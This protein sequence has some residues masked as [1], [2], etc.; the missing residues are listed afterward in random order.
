MTSITI[1]QVYQVLEMADKCRGEIVPCF[2]GDPGI[3]KTESVYRF[4]EDHGRN[5]VEMILSQRQ[6]TEI[7]GLVMP[8]NDTKS[9]EVFDHSRLSELK[10]GD[11]LLFDELLEAPPMVLSACLT[12]IQERRMMS[13]KKLPDILICAATNPLSSPMMIKESVRQRFMWFTVQFSWKVFYNHI[14][15][16]FGIDLDDGITAWVLAER[17]GYNL[18]TPRSITKLIELG[19]TLDL[20]MSKD[21]EAFEFFGDQLFQ[22]HDLTLKILKSLHQ[23]TSQDLIAQALVDAYAVGDLASSISGETII[24]INSKLEGLASSEI[25]EV[26]KSS[27]SAGE[28]E[29]VAKVLAQVDSEVLDA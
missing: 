8:D 13:G 18:V 25:L 21:R 19:K 10:D 23:L 29:S 2:V 4:A 12:L 17:T 9:M 11:I 28:F 7:S 22:N 15:R 26:L 16:R 6:P 3:G 24:E 5:V 27:L 20:S 14:K 1:D